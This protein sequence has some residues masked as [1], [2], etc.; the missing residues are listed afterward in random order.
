MR[1]YQF[2]LSPT[3]KQERTFKQ[4]LDLCCETYNAALD[5][6]KS[7]SRMAGV[8]LSYEDQC[9]EL[10][11]CK[12]ARPD[13]ASV[14]SQVLQDVLKRVDLAFEA[15]FQRVEEGKTPGFPRFKSRFRYH[16]LTFKQSGNS[17]KIHPAGKKK[18][19]MLELAKLGRV[20]MIQHR[21]IKGTPKTAI[22]KR[23]PTGKWFVSITVELSEQ[24][25]QEKRLPFSGEEVGIDVGLKTFAY[26]STNEEIA[27]P[28]FFRLEEAALSRANRAL[29]KAPKGSKE[30]G[31]KRKVV[32]RRH[33]RIANRRKHFIEQETRKL[34]AR[35][36]FIAVEALA[37][38]NM[39]K[40][41]KLAKSIA[42]ASWSMF[43]TRLLAKAEEAGRQVVRVNPAYTSQTC[44][45]CGHRQPMLLSARIYE[46]PHCG[47]VIHRDHNGS[48]NILEE[49]H[50]AV[51]RHS[52]VIPEA[53]ACS[54]GESSQ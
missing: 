50:Q 49:A 33:E 30:R 45:S 46:C 19:G 20:K 34:V 24:D 10:P 31:K 23:T 32:A 16:S 44:S 14:P 6:R 21:P 52:R 53:P 37:V 28:R 39:V 48:L 35:F 8:A 11:D 3:R 27:N 25:R 5:E 12:A 29:A 15:F 47:L 40:N 42:D 2:R 18:Q 54:R 1:T 7:A 4:W 51:G 26:L 38:R 17:F 36:D 9:A 43:F 41:P 22:V 13:L